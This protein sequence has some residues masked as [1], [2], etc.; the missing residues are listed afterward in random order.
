[1][2]FVKTATDL[3]TKSNMGQ[4]TATDLFTKNNDIKKTVNFDCLFFAY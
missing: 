2:P 1:M 4:Q 3:F